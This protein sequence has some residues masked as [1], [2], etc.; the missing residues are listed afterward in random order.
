MGLIR[1]G[2]TYLKKAA[3]LFNREFVDR[4]NLDLFQKV[5]WVS[6]G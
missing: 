5:L 6:V 2:K 1:L 3:S 4:K